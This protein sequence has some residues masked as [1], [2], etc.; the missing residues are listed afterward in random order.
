[1]LRLFGVAGVDRSGRPLAG[2]AV[3][4]WLASAHDGLGGGVALPFAMALA[5]VRPRATAARDGR[6]VRAPSTWPWRPSCCASPIAA[7]S[8]RPRRRGSPAPPSS[9]WTA[10]ASRAASSSTCSAKRDGRGSARRSR[11]PIS[12]EPSTRS[13]TSRL[14]ATTCSG[15][16]SRSVARWPTGCTTPASTCPSGTR[17]TAP[18]SGRP[19]LPASRARPARPARPARATTPS[20]PRRPRRAASEP[21][22][23]FAASPTASP[24]N[25]AAT[26]ASRW[27]SP[28]SACRRARSSPRSSAST[29][30]RPTRSPRSWP[31]AST[32]IARWR[33]TPSPGACIVARTR[34]SRSVPGRWSSRRTSPRGCRRTWRPGRVEPWRCSSLAWPS[35]ARMGSPGERIVVGAYPGWLPDEPAATARVL[36]EVVVRRRAF[37]DQLMRFDEPPGYHGGLAGGRGLAVP[38]RRGVGEVGHGF[39]SSC[40]GPTPIPAGPR[41]RG[42]PPRPR[43]RRSPP[44]PR[45]G[46]WA[47]PRRRTRRRWSRRPC[48]R[49]SASAISAGVPSWAS[50]A[51]DHGEGARSRRAI[52][53]D[54]VA[55][56]TEAFDPLAALD[57]G[58]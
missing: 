57:P 30:S 53:G 28:R 43:R 46:T 18:R 17:A 42:A 8:P 21:W 27:P 23:A 13:P 6:G 19:A 32:R 12:T 29:S 44:C 24:P 14:P 11:S 20:R 45:L 4:R 38:G 47:V 2:A 51:R 5:R 3:D 48:R 54:A 50:S 56:R 16:R 22:P 10:T 58:R 1:M 39:P 7:R 36:A 34:S 52:G 37:P 26:S 31:V 33:I 40:A 35:P 41:P 55:E 25:A 9:A 15:S 49:W